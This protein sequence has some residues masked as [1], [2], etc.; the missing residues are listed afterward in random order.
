M[1]QQFEMVYEIELPNGQELCVKDPDKYPG[2]KVIG[3]GL[4]PVFMKEID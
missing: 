3:V 1:S 4:F 2:A